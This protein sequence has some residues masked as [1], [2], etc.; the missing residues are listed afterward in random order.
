MSSTCA[1]VRCDAG[2]R[3]QSIGSI[4][5]ISAKP[6]TEAS[7]SSPPRVGTLPVE[8]GSCRMAI[9]PPVKITAMRGMARCYAERGAANRS[10]LPIPKQP[11]RFTM[12]RAVIEAVG[13]HKSFGQTHA[14]AGLDFDVAEGKILGMLGPNGAGK[15]TAVRILTTLT[16]PDRGS[17]RVAG[18]DVLK[19]PG[20]V[21][22]QIGVAGQNA[23]LDE[24]LTG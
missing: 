7:R 6:G 18:I 20:D 13:L 19:H 24:L 12:T 10:T 11:S 1:K 21:R 3:P 14:L 5:A 22:R 15:T 9:V 8:P 17:A 4:W 2:T 16:H 23:A